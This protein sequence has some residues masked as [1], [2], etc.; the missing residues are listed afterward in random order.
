VIGAVGVIVP[1]HDEE[2]L[3]G[4]CLASL[5]AAARG[6]GVPVHVAVVL[7]ACRDR[8]EAV[9]RQACVTGGLTVLR[10]DHRSV[11]PARAAGARALLARHADVDPS[12]LWL[13]TTDADSVVPA[14]WL[15]LQRMLADDGADAVAGTV[16]VV[17]WAGHP[18]KVP[19]RYDGLYGSAQTAPAHDHVHGANLGVRA[20]AY[21]AAGGFAAVPRN[22]D[23]R[24]W[25]TLQAM[26][27]PVVSTWAE[28]VVTSARLQART[29]GGFADFLHRLARPT[30]GPQTA[31][32]LSGLAEVG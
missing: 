20:S 15:A 2:E 17:D 1:A 22:E 3:L 6:A 29:T 12:S 8:S 9:T 24:L 11:G 23:H 21:L 26:G 13:A 4:A 14:R 16:V 5:D 30:D 10:T 28:P 18:P 7:D 32:T 31:G 27:R 25:R 19:R